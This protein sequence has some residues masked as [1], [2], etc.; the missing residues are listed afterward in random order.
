MLLEWLSEQLNCQGCWKQNQLCYREE[1]R[2]RA[3]PWERSPRFTPRPLWTGDGEK[4]NSAG[5]IPIA[6]GGSIPNHLSQGSPREFLGGDG[7]RLHPVSGGG[8]KNLRTCKSS[9]NAIP[10]KGIFLHRCKSKI[11]NNNHSLVSLKKK[12]R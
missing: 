2:H 9:W 7:I 12:K 6:G 11:K 1:C 10:K 8:Y 4:E 3:Q 5:A